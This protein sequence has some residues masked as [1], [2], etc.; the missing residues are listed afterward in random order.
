[1][2]Y[3]KHAFEMRVKIQS[4]TASLK[5]ALQIAGEDSIPLETSTID[6]SR[7]T[8][9]ELK[10]VEEEATED[11]HFYKQFQGAAIQIKN[12]T[13]MQRTQ[14]KEYNCPGCNSRMTSVPTFEKHKQQCTF[15]AVSDY[16]GRFQAIYS[17]KCD[18]KITEHEFILREIREIFQANDEL[19]KLAKG[20][21][22]PINA[23]APLPPKETD[24]TK[25]PFFKRPGKFSPDQGYTS[26]DKAN[27]SQW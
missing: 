8:K 26:G 4:N 13:V 23:V 2:G 22:L 16:L 11:Q 21:K 19:R 14:M 18:N 12:P 5:E 6:Q 3:L 10:D 20:W 1:M 15:S 27:T 24:Q 17:M 7:I 9:R 25:K